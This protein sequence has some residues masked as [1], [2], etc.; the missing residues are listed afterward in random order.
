M[1]IKRKLYINVLF[2]ALSMLIVALL[3]ILMLDRVNRAREEAKIAGEIAISA[4]ERNAFRSQYLR[5]NNERAKVQW[6][7]KHEQINKLLKSA[8]EIFKDSQDEETIHR[9]IENQEITWKLFSDIVNNR[10]TQRF[11]ADN[12]GVSD[13]IESRLII[14]LEMRLTDK[15]LH[16]RELSDAAGRRLSSAL[17]LASWSIIG[18]IAIVTAAS[19]INSWSMGR[20]V[21]SRTGRL[22]DGVFVIGQGKL[23]QRID[24]KGDDEFAELAVSFN[25]MT[26]RLQESY[27]N[28]EIEIAERKQA[29]EELRNSK[30]LSEA[31]NRINAVIHSSLDPDVIMQR[32]VMESA[33]AIQVDAS[34][35][36]LFQDGAFVMRYMHRMPQDLIGQPLSYENIHGVHYAV[37]AKNVVAFND[38]AH[39]DRLSSAFWGSLGVKSVMVAPLIVREAA[40][41][42]LSFYGVSDRVNFTDGYIDFARKLAASLSL[43]LEN[44]RLFEGRKSMEEEMRHMAHHDALTGLPN[45]RLFLEIVDI[46][47]AQARRDHR[48]LAILFLDL[49]RFKEINDTL[50]HEAGDEL[51]AEVAKRLKVS[52]RES[53]NIARTGGDEFNIILT[54]FDHAEDVAL[55]AGKIMRSFQSPFFIAGHY[56]HM[57]TSIG[58]SIYPDDSENTD[59]LFRYADIAMYHAKDLGKNTYQFYNSDI[60]VRSVEKIR[61]EGDLRQAIGRGE[62]SVHYQPQIDLRTGHIVCAEALVRWMH[63]ELGMLPP[64]RFIPAAEESGF[65]TTIDEWVLRTAC[66]QFKV[67]Q[68]AGYPPLCVTVNL[69]AREFQ[70]PG[71][72]TTITGILDETGLP[73][74]CLDIEITESVAMRDIEHTVKQ[75]HELTAMG[76]R[77]SVDDFGT[78]YSSLSYLK[79]LPIQRLKI[80]RSFVNDITTDPDDRA[81]I[82]AITAMAHNM[83]M[84]V[85]AEGVETEEQLKFLKES[86]CD[87]AQGYLFNKPLSHE[88]FTELM[89]ATT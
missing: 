21:I 78:G 79:R 19:A 41:G 38:V 80:D 39:D 70:N 81:I 89:V 31:A 48:A 73:P 1:Q 61:M 53:D 44:A 52:L 82:Q 83:K 51:L 20:T 8:L 63:P 23:D 87:E 85:V 18:L 10:E 58:I 24:I 17:M 72:V 22:R 7:A 59:T 69:S 65:I 64:K 66:V 11:F 36:G 34:S 84:T 71:L 3:V 60:N 74:D 88:L 35:I 54:D 14:Q 68:N 15:L 2:L 42:A 26:A 6:I 43:A 16:T 33:Q 75:L 55:I 57:T 86:Q 67:W 13:E 47:I 37:E 77:I 29:E 46:E 45:R 4:F 30:E 27:H 76:V 25:E 50:G 28:L 49:D 12:S 32:V 9:L 40:I 62:L 5:T 56:L